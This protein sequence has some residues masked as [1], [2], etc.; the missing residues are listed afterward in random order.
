MTETVVASETAA[1]STAIS[2]IFDDNPPC[3]QL[4]SFIGH[5]NHP[6]T[7]FCIRI[8]AKHQAASLSTVR[9]QGCD[10]ERLLY[11]AKRDRYD[12]AKFSIPTKIGSCEIKPQFFIFPN[13]DDEIQID[14]RYAIDHDALQ[15]RNFSLCQRLNE[16][17]QQRLHTD[18]ALQHGINEFASVMH[19]LVCEFIDSI[20]FDSIAAGKTPDY[21]VT[22]PPR[23]GN[24]NL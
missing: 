17:M 5:P 1:T 2:Q 20:Y 11:K 9:M 15:G 16:E 24:L 18:V 21:L 12:T 13:K 4:D 7:L 22:T 8:P 14:Y 23:H 19:D 3:V 6:E 10:L